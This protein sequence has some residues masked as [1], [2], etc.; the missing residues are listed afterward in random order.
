[1]GWHSVPAED[2]QLYDSRAGIPARPSASLGASALLVAP[3]LRQIFKEE[4]VEINTKALEEFGP[5]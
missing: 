2:T 1:M 5:S 4:E 3:D